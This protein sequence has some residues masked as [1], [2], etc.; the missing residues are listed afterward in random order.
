MRFSVGTCFIFI[1]YTKRHSWPLKLRQDVEK[2]VWIRASAVSERFA[3]RHGAFEEFRRLRRPRAQGP[4][5][6]VQA[7]ELNHTALAKLA[8][9]HLEADVL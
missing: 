1:L 5:G 9:E 7:H 4:N 6:M 3:L 8:F 2:S